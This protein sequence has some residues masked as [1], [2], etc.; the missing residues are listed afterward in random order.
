MPL[1]FLTSQKNKKLLILNGY[2]YLLHREGVNKMIQHCAKY[3]TNKCSSRCYTTKQIES[4][5][6]ISSTGHNH[7]PKIEMIT[8]KQNLNEMKDMT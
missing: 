2:T 4:G 8:V 3:F 5:D 7:A 1:Q 6:V